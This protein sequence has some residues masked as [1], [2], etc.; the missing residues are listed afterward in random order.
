M[1]LDKG[2]ETTKSLFTLKYTKITFSSSFLY[3][4]FKKKIKNQSDNFYTS[5]YFFYSQRK[6]E[7]E[8]G[9]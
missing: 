2:L 9:Q 3:S 4:I 6:R 5:L 7:K 1:G 8:K